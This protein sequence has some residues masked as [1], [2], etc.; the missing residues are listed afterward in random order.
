MS[1]VV[2]RVVVGVGGSP[3]SLQALRHAVGLA[4]GYQ[5]SL[6]AVLAWTP[7]GGELQARRWPTA[8]L[9]LQWQ[10]AAEQSLRVAF[11]EGLGGVPVDVHCELVIIRGETGPAL[12]EVADRHSDLLVVGTGR[13]GRFGR[14][15][16][17]R[18][19][20][21]C[22]ANARCTVVA[23]PPPPLA[24]TRRSHRVP[25]QLRVRE[26]PAAAAARHGSA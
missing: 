4:R 21:H 1:H 7:P 16:H 22:A 11:D 15:L 17:A 9:G 25:A 10:A 3:A 23:V 20:A 8:R 5:A 14:L 2:G 26:R 12:V 13:R 24:G 19:A 6:V 18:V